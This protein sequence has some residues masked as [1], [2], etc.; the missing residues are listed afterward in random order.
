M[1]NRNIYP[2]FE[3]ILEV[4]MPVKYNGI[5]YTG[6]Y[7]VSNLG[8]VK[9]LRRNIIFRLPN[10]NTDKYIPISI[11]KNG[12]SQIAPVHRIVYSSIVGPIDSTDV[13]DH[14]DSDRLNNMVHNL[15]K[16]THRINIARACAKKRS[17]PTGITLSGCGKK[18]GVAV[19][20]LGENI[21]MG[22]YEDIDIALDL[23]LLIVRLIEHKK[24]NI[25]PN[26]IRDIANAF[27]VRH[28][29]KPIKPKPQRR[30]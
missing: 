27:R 23:R 10:N 29:L 8:R 2:P 1:N 7:K 17:L 12:K 15:N 3:S 11:K 25:D 30:Y 4:W 26:D 9:D 18:Y 24:V 14:L 13:I 20:W 21:T 6:L 5:D 22:L 19:G 28:N 16:T